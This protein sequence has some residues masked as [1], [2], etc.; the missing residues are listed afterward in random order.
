M[1][2][3]RGRK[4]TLS[5]YKSHCE[6]HTLIISSKPVIISS[7]RLHL[8][9]AMPCEFGLHLMHWV[10]YYM[11]ALGWGVASV[12]LEKPETYILLSNKL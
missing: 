7:V 10:K 5:L 8:Q 6:D 3:E 1:V 2:M 12:A 9:M 11:C 4:N